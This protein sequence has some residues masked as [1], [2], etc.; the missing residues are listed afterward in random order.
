MPYRSMTRYTFSGRLNMTSTAN[1]WAML[2]MVHHMSTGRLGICV[3][4]IVLEAALRPI[5]PKIK[6]IHMASSI[7]Q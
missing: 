3:T 5:A 2:I 7:G 1:G 4:T 6:R